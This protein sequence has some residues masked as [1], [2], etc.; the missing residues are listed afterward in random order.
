MEQLLYE[1]PR[2]KLRFKGAAS[3]S[4]TELLQIIIGS[5]TPRYPVAKIARALSKAIEARNDVPTYD[6]L[7]T[8][9]GMGHAKVSL[10]LAIFELGRRIEK[11]K[12]SL[13]S[14]RGEQLNSSELK[15]SKRQQLVYETYD[16]SGLLLRHHI[17]SD[18]R[19]KYELYIRR[20]CA[21][22]VADK[23]ATISIALGYSDQKLSPTTEELHF[24][25]S[26][27]GNFSILQVK[28]NAILFVN[29]QAEAVIARSLYGL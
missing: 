26:L 18:I 14:D 2:E 10:L 23:A 21:D 7:S 3:L 29:A 28:I 13:E 24:I 27:A 1:R 22:L 17:I 12:Q 15:K 4:L 25:Q 9:H 20:I 5:G 6:E 16:G 11:Q 8:I 19:N